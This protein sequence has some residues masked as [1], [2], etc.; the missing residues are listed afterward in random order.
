VRGV[1]DDTLTIRELSRETGVAPGTLRMWESRHGF[2]RPERASGGH[3]RYRREDVAVVG[4]VLRHRSAGLSLSAAIERARG[5]SP[6]P[7]RSIFAALRRRCPDLTPRRVTKPVMLAMSRAVEDECLARASHAVL[8]ASFQRA[9]FYR[10]ARDRWTELAAV[11]D[12]AFVLADFPRTDVRASPARVAIGRD[13]PAAREWSIACL[14]DDLCACL[15]GWEVPHG[16]GLPDGDRT[17]E[18][19]W[20]TDGDAAAVALAAAAALARGRAPTLAERVDARVAAW[21]GG[22]AEQRR[23]GDALVA[24]MLAHLGDAG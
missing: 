12:V 5:W 15:A 19:V 2:P 23:T 21:D 3:R 18:A 17:F 22:G 7:D 20:S 4:E 6:E 10:P 13:Q 11:A 14:A 1:D 8:A 9:R 24:R 16:A